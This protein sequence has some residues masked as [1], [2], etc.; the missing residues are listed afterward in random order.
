MG[1]SR[2]D[3]RM[4]RGRSGQRMRAALESGGLE[5]RCCV[6]EGLAGTLLTTAFKGVCYVLQSKSRCY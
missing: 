3:L 2:A 5:E 1:I 4:H 6:K